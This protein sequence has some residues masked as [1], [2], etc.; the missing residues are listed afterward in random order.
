MLFTDASTVRSVTHQPITRRSLANVLSVTKVTCATKMWTNVRCRRRVGTEPLAATLPALI[1]ACVPPAT[2]VPIVLSTPTTA[3][4]VS[5]HF[6]TAS[7]SS[8]S[9]F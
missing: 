8:A 6:C 5:F 1:S 4:L 3:L 2:R 9:T 7:L